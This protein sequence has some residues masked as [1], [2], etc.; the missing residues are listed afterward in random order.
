MG[1]IKIPE[2]PY[3]EALE[4]Y[5][6]S[7]LD[8]LSPRLVVLFGS[9][10]R[11]DFGVGSDVDLLI[12]A[13]DFPERFDDRLRLLFNLN[14]TTAPLEPIGYTPEEFEALLMRRHPTALYAMEEGIPLYDDGLYQKMKEVFERLKA[15][16]RLV[17][18]EGGWYAMKIIEECLGHRS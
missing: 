10:A 18:G 15:D 3:K 8:E 16:L 17:K 14:P 5:L 7:L 11:G 4:A 1:E 13:E 2:V 6:R 12:I 9:A